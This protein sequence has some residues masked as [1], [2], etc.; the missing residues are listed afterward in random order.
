MKKIACI[1]LIV[2]L[3]LATTLPLHAKPQSESKTETTVN[4]FSDGSYAI[5]THT[6]TKV[7]KTETSNADGGMTYGEIAG[8]D[9]I[10]KSEYQ[11]DKISIGSAY[12]NDE[13]VVSQTDFNY[14][15]N[16]GDLLLEFTLIAS[17]EIVPCVK[18]ICTGYEY[19]FN[20]YDSSWKSAQ[21]SAWRKVDSAYESATFKHKFLFFTVS[22]VN[23]NIR[24][25]CDG[26]GNI[27][28]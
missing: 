28:H 19:F 4:T 11:G 18:A 26:Y 13:L 10:V 12:A 2:C 21:A 8:T 7:D 25:H 27:T 22:T 15:N 1:G 17:F 3:L 6:T 24:V 16:E 14:Y 5:T 20:I 23:V 9:C